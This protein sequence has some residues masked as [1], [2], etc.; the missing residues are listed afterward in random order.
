MNN[1]ATHIENV[2]SD[3]LT[4]ARALVLPSREAMLQRAASVQRFWDGNTAL[5]TQAWQAWEANGESPSITPDVSWLDP[6]LRD[7]VEQA[8]QDPSKEIAVKDLWQ[9]V[10][11][12]VFQAQF[13]DMNK[14]ADLRDYLDAVADA[15]IPTRPPYGIAL[16]RHGA[17]LDPRSTGYLAAPAFQAFYHTL[18]DRFMRPIAR[19]MFPGVMGYDS[20]TFGFSIQYQPGMDTSLQPHTDASAATLNINMNLPGECFTGSEVDFYDQ[21]SGKVERTIFKP[22]A[23]M[24]H[25]GNIPHAAQPITSGTRSNMVLWLYGDR[26]QIPLNTS[27]DNAMLAQERWVHLDAKKDDIA[28]F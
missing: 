11:P 2:I 9:E 12:G 1:T 21:T 5:L 8:W 25:R 20:Q 24:I 14:L 28:P 18:M 6:T 23:A 7:A 10:L 26:G 17:M 16:N 27:A 15:G 13:F 3:P 19:L 22:G 4:Q